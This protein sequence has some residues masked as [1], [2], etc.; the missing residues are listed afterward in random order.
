MIPLRVINL[1]RTPERLAAFAAQN[2][3]LDFERF[4]AA[5]GATRPRAAWIADGLITPDNIYSS[6][7]IGCAASHVAL[8]RDC[9]ARQQACHVVEDD[10]I[11][12]RDFRAMTEALLQRTDW[13]VVYWTWNF[14]WPLEFWP[15]DGLA[16]A[17]LQLDPQLISEQY[18]AFAAAATPSQLVRIGGGAGTGCYAI[19]PGGAAKLLKL[20]LPIGAQPTKITVGNLRLD[21]DNTGIDVEAARH[22]RDLRAFAALPPLA[23]ARNE[24]ATSTIRGPT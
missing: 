19:A 21:W 13:D 23:A 14:N 7:A 3:G 15:A 10:V 24:L 6:G 18:D 4:A 5:D 17:L 8:W 20:C 1:D 2:P 16:P 11:L 22:F 12:R 9:V